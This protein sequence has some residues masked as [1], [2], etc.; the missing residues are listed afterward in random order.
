MIVGHVSVLI[1]LPYVV[2]VLIRIIGK[3]WY[4]VLKLHITGLLLS[5]FCVF[6]FYLDMSVARLSYTHTKV[7]IG[8][9]FS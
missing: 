3:N 6:G 1:K 7:F 5:L 9:Y 2:I 4:P 8:N